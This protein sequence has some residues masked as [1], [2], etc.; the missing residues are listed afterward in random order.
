MTGADFAFTPLTIETAGPL[1][2]ARSL[3]TS[4]LKSVQLSAP[5]AGAPALPNIMLRKMAAAE[6]PVTCMGILSFRYI[7]IGQGAFEGFRGESDGFRQCG[8]G[9]DGQGD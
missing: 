4:H 6:V 7:K 2:S 9:M 3:L 1:N 5:N 8:V